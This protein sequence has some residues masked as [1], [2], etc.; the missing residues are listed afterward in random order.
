[1]PLERIVSRVDT[2]WADVSNQLAVYRACEKAVCSHHFG[3][4]FD[5][6]ISTR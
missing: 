1:M 6:G 4:Y 5:D 2:F 3:L